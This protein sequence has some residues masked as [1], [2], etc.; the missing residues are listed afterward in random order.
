LQFGTSNRNEYEKWSSEVCG[1]CCLEM[2]GDAYSLTTKTP[3]Y[4]LTMECKQKGGLKE[5]P[6]GEIQG[7][8]HN[9]Y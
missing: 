1:I 7:V 4:Q 3:L 5:L 2:V 8:F 6:S 9:F